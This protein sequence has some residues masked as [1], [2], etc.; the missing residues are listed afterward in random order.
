MKTQNISK[1]ALL[2]LVGVAV[3]LFVLFIFAGDPENP[4]DS[5]TD[6]LIYGMYAYVGIMVAG[7]V[8]NMGLSFVNQDWGLVRVIIAV[9]ATLV[10]YAIF[11]YAIVSG[12]IEPDLQA[13][14]IA[15]KVFDAE[16]QVATVKLASAYCYTIYTLTLLAVLAVIGCAS[17]L[18][19]KLGNKH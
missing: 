12:D 10:L 2:A 19:Y 11:R 15:G 6:Y 3:L 14:L 9:V 13:K 17:G 18:I 1:Y 8:A 4:E 16:E 7:M 5:W